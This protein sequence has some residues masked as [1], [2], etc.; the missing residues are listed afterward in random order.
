MYG[1]NEAANRDG[2]DY[3]ISRSRSWKSSVT[4]RSSSI[5]PL[6]SMSFFLLIVL[7][8]SSRAVLIRRVLY[9]SPVSTIRSLINVSGIFKVAPSS[10]IFQRDR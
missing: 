6:I 5:F 9:C 3:I 8:I 4:V 1:L 7:S 10:E 2:P